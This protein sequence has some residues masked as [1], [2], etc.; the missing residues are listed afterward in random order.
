MAA[1]F[2]DRF[3]AG[4]RMIDG[5]ELNDLVDYV[6]DLSANG[7][8][9]SEKGQPGGVATLDGSGLVTSSQIPS[10]AALGAVDL[11]TAQTIAGVKTFSSSPIVP[12]PS[13]G[14]DAANKNYV[15]AQIIIVNDAMVNLT[16]A[17]TVAGVKTFSDSPIVPTPTTATQASTKGYVDGLDGANV[18][19]T[20]AQTVA[21][22][23]TFSDSPIVP[24]PTTDTQ[25]STKLYV[26]TG[27]NRVP[28]G[29]VRGGVLQQAAITDA[30][31]APTQAEF[32]AVLA[33]L[34]S[35][36]VIAT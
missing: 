4:T 8:P 18:K 32:N 17:Q 31:A 14:P 27:D 24:E 22:V 15:D 19:L 28:T 5:A 13:S 34:R 9:S 7:I 2:L 12:A 25:A 11:T 16:T 29:A 20:G 35:A 30:P 21:G 1:P 6:N 10:A 26:D 3:Q 36:G 33:A 23:K